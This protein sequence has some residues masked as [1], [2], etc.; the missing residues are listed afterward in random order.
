M[1]FTD[2]AR[3]GS[4]SSGCELTD[5]ATR[6]VDELATC[7][8]LG[9]S[10]QPTPRNV[11]SNRERLGRR[12]S[13]ARCQPVREFDPCFATNRRNE[14]HQHKTERLCK[15]SRRRL[16]MGGPGGRVEQPGILWKGPPLSSSLR[17]GRWS[18]PHLPPGP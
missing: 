8:S 2:V 18:S 7:W 4:Q 16:G 5:E 14:V 11:F 17:A 15:S 10:V 9:D 3:K 13:S 12:A 6:H 1:I